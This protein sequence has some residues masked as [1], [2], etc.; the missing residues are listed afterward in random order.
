MSEDVQE[1]ISRLSR[2]GS[3]RQ[4][5]CAKFAQLPDDKVSRTL[6]LLCESSKFEARTALF[7]LLR[8]CGS[9]TGARVAWERLSASEDRELRAEALETAA[10]LDAGDALR[11]LPLWLNDADPLL[12]ARVLRRMRLTRDPLAAE[13]A[14]RRKDDVDP[15]VRL[16]VT[17]IFAEC[18]HP[19]ARRLLAGMASD[20]D[21]RCRTAAMEALWQVSP[22]DALLAAMALQRD[23][24]SGTN[25]D[26]LIVLSRI[27][28]SELAR[29][30]QQGVTS[31]GD[32]INPKDF[33]ALL[34]RAPAEIRDEFLAQASAPRWLT[35][36][37]IEYDSHAHPGDPAAV[38]RLTAACSHDSAS[39]RLN[40]VDALARHHRNTRGGTLGPL[41]RHSDVA[42]RRRT[43]E[44]LADCDA[45]AM[46]EIIR[47]LDDSDSS[48]R[49]LAYDA[50]AAHDSSHQPKLW[51]K[52]I[53]DDAADIRS[54]A[55]TKL[56]ALP[57]GAVV[58]EALYRAARS[59]DASIRRQAVCTLLERDA[60]R[61][62]LARTIRDVLSEALE[63]ADS[64]IKPP[65]IVLLV[66]AVAQFFPSGTLDVL[67]LAA[68]SR[69]T[70]VR[71]AAALKLLSM[72]RKIALVAASELIETE[73]S[74]VLRRVAQLL[75]DAG[76][77]RGLIPVV[78]A[79]DE[80]PGAAKSMTPLLE[81]FP[82]ARNVRFLL[83]ALKMRWPSVKRYAARE[84]IDLDSPDMIE[85]LLQATKDSD[86]DVQ[87]AAMQ[88]LAKFSKRPEV[89]QRLIEIRD[90]D[91]DQS[92][93][94][95]A[96]G[97][98]LGVG[99]AG[100]IEPLL[101]ATRDDDIEVQLASVQAL[102]KFATR[103]EV[104]A[105]LI[106][107]L[108]YG[109]IAV[110]EKCV[111]TLGEYQIKAAVEPLIRM[112]NN[113]FLKFRV[114]EALMRI[115]DRKGY[116]AIKRVKIR[117]KMFGQKKQKGPVVPAGRKGKSGIRSK[118]SGRK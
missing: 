1:L 106:E 89:Y 69:D 64:P 17:R 47:A 49:R 111:E 30:I 101:E 97:S 45:G 113:P 21:E 77:Q 13:A 117:E 82:Q 76:D 103:P 39:I 115:G 110:R 58:N 118:Y 46:R 7:E 88:A 116:L 87:R 54:Y 12:R 112:L 11:L 107:M 40:A 59:A 72:N 86:P 43:V 3:D 15:A 5:E 8:A 108:S 35:A 80:C 50:L 27:D 34:Q 16:E 4:S 36:A 20:S 70:L 79:L 29:I 63:S 60:G 41:L 38:H 96:V 26:A 81:R 42:V 84:L 67:I 10:R 61:P 91:G 57:P 18:P 71:R 55:L 109:D 90:S 53:A 98:L 73:D 102:G 75:A 74:D 19:G 28:H 92:L 114:Q 9:A 95:Q 68:K 100:V 44:A 33:A 65:Q 25:L 66:N 48:V 22:F 2:P 83:S 6:E 23:S 85:P 105:R 56:L 78:R 94:Q 93:R 31:A 99:D 62:A 52:G 24:R 104:N 32:D 37:L 51:Q 14:L